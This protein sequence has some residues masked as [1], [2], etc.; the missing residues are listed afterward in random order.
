MFMRILMLTGQLAGVGA[1][2]LG[3][4]N[5][6]FHISFIE[7]HML[8]GVIVTLA[9]LTVGLLAVFTRELRAL[10][11]VVVVF[12]LIVPVFGINQV[13]ILM[14]NFHWLIQVAHL[15]VGMAAVTL[16]ERIGKQYVQ[17]KQKPVADKEAIKVS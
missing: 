3:L 10:G 7:I 11:I 4:L 17:V 14:G 13:Q 12:A 6:F 2:I 15:L 16:I 1:I 9:L 5:W 8:F